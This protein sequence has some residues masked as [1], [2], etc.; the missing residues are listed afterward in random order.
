ML[1]FSRRFY[2]TFL[3]FGIGA[4]SLAAW[5]QTRPKSDVIPEIAGY[6]D[7]REVTQKPVEME[8][9]VAVA[10]APMGPMFLKSRPPLPPTIQGTQGPHAKKYIRVYVNE[11]G[12][13]AMTT[14]KT[15]RFPVGS[16]IV[17][18]KLPL[19]KSKNS[20]T[21][22]SKSPVVSLTPE[23]LTIMIKREK[24]YDA[25]NG[26]WEYMVSD[27]AGKTVAE[28]GK[29]ASC[30]GCHQP[31][32]KTDYIVRS[33]LPAEV[34]KALRDAEIAPIAPPSEPKTSNESERMN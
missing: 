31:F 29:L 25:K 6:A 1:R 4:M 28:R 20:K 11:V 21:I 19:V 22:Q 7:W 17:K 2:A 33:Y 14:Q 16:V 13:E 18:Q 8:P 27:G 34:E 32:D 30:Q 9:R 26:D 5:A 15:P 12:E 10:C 23:L 24:D 3:S